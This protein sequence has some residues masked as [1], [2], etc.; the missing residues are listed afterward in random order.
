MVFDLRALAFALAAV[1]ITEVLREPAVA[2]RPGGIGGD[3]AAM[4]AR[5]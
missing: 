2:A 4:I 1:T 3:G 5:M